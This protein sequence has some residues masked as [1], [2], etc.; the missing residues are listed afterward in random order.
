MIAI[1][2]P[3]DES[4]H[5]PGN[6]QM[7]AILA[8]SRDAVDK[9]YAKALDLGASDEGAPGERLPIFYGAYVRNLDGNKLCFFD[10]KIG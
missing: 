4:A 5:P 2:T 8:G 3:Y 1:C 10:M 9:M 7:L 6:G